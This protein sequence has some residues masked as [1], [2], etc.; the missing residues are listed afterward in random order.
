MML[1]ICC[2][3]YLFSHLWFGGS[4]MLYIAVRLCSGLYY[5]RA[6]YPLAPV[7]LLRGH[8]VWSSHLSLCHE[9][10]GLAQM[11]K[12][13]VN[14]NNVL[15]LI[16]CTAT[17]K[18]MHHREANFWLS[19]IH[20][21]VL[22]YISTIG[23]KDKGD[24]VDLDRCPYCLAFRKGPVTVTDKVKYCQLITFYTKVPAGFKF[25]SKGCL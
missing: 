8:Q 20:C 7:E 24:E 17:P 5:N 2:R 18:H 19:S 12:E 13:S 14:T 15:I 21:S 11:R 23:G 6:G 16:P 25:Q 10:G 9:M 22:Y 4:F 1:P 3:Y